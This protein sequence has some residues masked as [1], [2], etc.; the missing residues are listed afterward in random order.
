MN[1]AKGIKKKIKKVKGSATVEATIVLPFFLIV[2]FSLAYIINIFYT[3]NTV[4]A[5][6]SEVA[7]RI[8]NMS[9]FYHVSGLKE[10]SDQL[11]DMAQE[12]GGTL[13][14][15]KDT[16]TNA[17]DSFND[18]ISGAQNAVG[19]G[20]DSVDD[21]KKLLENA[22]DFNEN[23]TG[24]SD[25]VQTI[26]SDPKNELKLFMTVFAQKL[27]YEATNRIICFIAKG[28]LGSELNK[29]VFSSGEDAAIN[30]GI[31][32]GLKG[33]NFN[34]SSVFGDTESLEFVVNYSIKAPLVFGLIPDFQLSNRVKIIA[35]TGGRGESAKIK[36][37][38]NE[39]TNLSE[40][41]I[42]VQMDQDKKYWDRGLEIEDMQVEKLIN[43]SKG[44]GIE[45]FATA[46]S[47]SLIDAYT[48]DISTGAVEY[49][50][51]FTLNPFMKTYSE[52]HSA[53]SYEIKKHS[54]RLLECEAPDY[55]QG[56]Q[57]KTLKRIV[58]LVIPVNSDP[59]AEEA[60]DKACQE[61]KK[62]DIEVRLVRDYGSYS[63]PEEIQEPAEAA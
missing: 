42:W 37:V 35:W 59:Y 3:Y 31:K 10:Y 9:Y 17:F 29:R 23:M 27:S 2:L 30:L 22:K 11:N 1:G 38:E 41:S 36:N 32:D 8:G 26:I 60:Y 53:I 28:D 24:A 55:F 20:V 7:R 34:Q 5:S 63:L 50:D 43:E 25:L 46:K 47:Y 49:Y 62:F 18:T 56:V 61:L 6:L 40:S 13:E 21:I 33:M 48:Y 52:K 16:I 44:K 57:V 14:D 4:Q 12:A 58:I 15:Q 54:K 19:F 51:V 39:E 45:A